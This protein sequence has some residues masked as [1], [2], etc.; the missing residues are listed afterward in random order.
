[1]NSTPHKLFK[2]VVD[3]TFSIC[4]DN[5]LAWG[6]ILGIREKDG[7]LPVFW[8]GWGNKIFPMQLVGARLGG[9]CTPPN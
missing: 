9:A 8:V 6:S 3:G 1:M 7:G 4:F 2:S 5:G